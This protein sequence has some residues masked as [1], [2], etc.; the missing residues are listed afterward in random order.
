MT[1][2]SGTTN[3][4]AR[5]NIEE[6]YSIYLQHPL[7]CTDSRSVQSGCIFFALK[8]ENFNGN[9]FA[10]AALDQGALFSVVD[11]KK[12]AT[13]ERCILVDDVLHT[14]QQLANHHRNQ[15]KIPF[16]AITGSNGKTTTKELVRNVLA[17]KFMTKATKGNLNNHIGVPLTI[18]SIPLNCQIAV[19]E[20]GANHLLEIKALCE[21]TEP[22]YGIITNIGKAH[23]EGFGGFEGVK[24]GKGELY[25][26]ITGSRGTVFLNADNQFLVEM[27]NDRRLGNRITY[28]T[29]HEC[30]CRGHLQTA[31]PTVKIR[32]EY[33]VCNSE[34]T[35]QLI[36]EYNFENILSA[37][38]IGNY[39]GVEANLINKAIEEY[40]PDNSRS[41]VIVRGTNTIILD[42]YN[43]NPTS[44]EAALKNFNE[45]NAGQKIIFLGDMAELG[46]ES[47]KEHEM[48]I[49]LLKPMNADEV[50]LVG[51]NF[52][53]WAGELH[54][55]YFE[56][57]EDAAR[58]TATQQFKNAAILIKGSRS[59]KMENVLG[60]L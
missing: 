45:I 3:T 59:M 36:G 42:A 60:V 39:F 25:D 34:V 1:E 27:A 37:I 44:V 24:K 54:C 13:D 15:L 7:V 8:G 43:A 11:E 21:I 19:I 4:F 28:G 57:S 47:A 48:V 46:A 16:L 18:L 38:C 31:M 26:F 22:D 51:K 20:M 23:L 17:Q 14:L 35:S 30:N 9:A 41:Q 49:H 5:M 10:T 52:G 40:V 32:W 56:T 33:G 58:W 2:Y 12:F 29:S 53:A 6:I 55:H 50:I